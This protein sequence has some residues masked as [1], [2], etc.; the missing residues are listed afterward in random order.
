MQ[1][2]RSHDHH[3]SA[4]EEGPGGVVPQPV[5]LVVSRRV[6]LDVRI[7]PGQVRLRL[8]VVVVADEV[9][10][11]VVREELAELL[12]ELRGQRLVVR[13]HQR[14][15]VD[16]F[17]QLG[18][19]VGLAGAGRA[20]QHLVTHSLVHAAHSP[21]MAVGAPGPAEP[22]HEL[23]DHEEPDQLLPDQVLPD[24]L[25]PDQLLLDQELPFQVPP[26]QL[27]P[28]ASRAAIASESNGLPKMSCSPVSAPRP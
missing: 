10:D 22:D 17:D 24:Q 14:G 3:V 8:E 19:G 2:H 7:G 18:G 28:S 6:L 12:V 26:D 21:S 4:L 23:P 11:R 13:H 15:P 9:L 20:Q 16:R 5:D 25:L 27:C 1:L